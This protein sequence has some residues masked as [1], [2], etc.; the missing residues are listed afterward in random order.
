MKAAVVS[1][2][3]H[4]MVQIHLPHRRPWLPVQVGV[5]TDETGVQVGELDAAACQGLGCC[6]N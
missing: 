1:C 3:P 5:E 4:A 2:I 6:I